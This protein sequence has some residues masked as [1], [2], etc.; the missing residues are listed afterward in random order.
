MIRH[1]TAPSILFLFGAIAAGTAH[2]EFN[3]VADAVTNYA[4]TDPATGKT[5]T[6]RA[7]ATAVISENMVIQYVTP[8]NLGISG[9]PGEPGTMRL[10]AIGNS[11]ERA[12][13]RHSAPPLSASVAVQGMPNQTFG[14]S[15]GQATLGANGQDGRVI[16]TFTHNAGKTPYVGPSGDTEFI[17]AASLR[18]ARNTAYRGYNGTLDVIVSHN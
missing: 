8:M 4:V 3:D 14:V 13:T 11:S 7:T 18:L 17:I 5:G 9:E 1:K 16:A 12:G 10:I 6:A 2:A 15:I